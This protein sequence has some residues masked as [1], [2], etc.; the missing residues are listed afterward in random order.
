MYVLPSMRAIGID[1]ASSMILDTEARSPNG[2]SS[3]AIRPSWSAPSF[4]TARKPLSTVATS[5]SSPPPLSRPGIENLAA[6]AV[7]RRARR[8]PITTATTTSMP[9][10]A[11]R[12]TSHRRRYRAPSS[13]TGRR[14]P[15]PEAPSTAAG[16]GGTG[17]LTAAVAPTASSAGSGSVGATGGTVTA[18]CDAA[19]SCR[20]LEQAGLEHTEADAEATVVEVHSSPIGQ[21]S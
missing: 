7:A 1:T 11:A 18:V 10:T 16:A 13:A 17:A 8:T 20:V 6:T 5:R 4:M 3:G 2:H 9:A 14:W 12:P 21:V 19:F 15:P